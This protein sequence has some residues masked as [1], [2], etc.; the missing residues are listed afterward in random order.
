MKR[1][2][3]YDE[4]DVKRLTPFGLGLRLLG[5]FL[6]V[7][8]VLSLTGLALGWF[9]ASTQVISPDNVKAQWQFAYDYNESLK[10]IAGQW[11]TAKSAEAGAA[12]ADEKLQRSSQRI[13]IENNYNRVKAQYDARLDDAFRARLVAPP[14]VPHRAPTLAD[15]VTQVGCTQQ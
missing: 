3:D 8:V 7:A 13:A 6:A 11:C 15:E 14:D 9:R 5:A 12:G 10:A 2:G 4:D 1:I